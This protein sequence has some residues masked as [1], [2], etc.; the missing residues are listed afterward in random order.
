GR[1][2]HFEVRR[3]RKESAPVHRAVLVEDPMRLWTKASEQDLLIALDRAPREKRMA[4]DELDGLGWL[5][6]LRLPHTCGGGSRHAHS[7]PNAPVDGDRPGRSIMLP[8]LRERVE[9]RVGGDVVD[10]PGGT[11]HRAGGREQEKEVEGLSR[12][13][14][15]EYES[16]VNLGTEHAFDAGLG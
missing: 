12:E 1:P 16:S 6:R 15:L 2:R 10:L 7:L 9:E 5:R 13:E 8:A 11:G 3:T 14:R 4:G